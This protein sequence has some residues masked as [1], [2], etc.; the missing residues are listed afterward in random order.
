MLF[1]DE[2]PEFARNVLEAL[3]EPLESGRVT[4][5]R[6]A[7]SIEFPADFQLVAAMNPCPCGFAGDPKHAC[8]CSPDRVQRYQAKVSGPFLDR[9]DI[10]LGMA[11]EP[12][13]HPSNSTLGETSAAVGERVTRAVRQQRARGAGINARLYGARL[14][15]VCQLDSAGQ[16][17]LRSAAERLGLSARGC[18]SALRVAR[19][20]ADLA[21]S[22]HVLAEHLAEAL[23]LRRPESVRESG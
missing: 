10:V 14:R 15:E 8:R 20:I 11:R 5:V 13:S 21:E 22:R 17:L 9:V 16:K 6:A 18:A 4:I 2:L 7:Y 19:T 3:R 1:L 23:I 12:Y